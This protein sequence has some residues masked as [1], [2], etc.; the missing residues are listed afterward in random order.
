MKL[1]MI[2][3]SEDYDHKEAVW[4]ALSEL[5]KAF[6]DGPVR[7]LAELEDGS[8]AGAYATMWADN[9]RMSTPSLIT[10]QRSNRKQVK[11]RSFTVAQDLYQA[12]KDAVVYLVVFK[13]S[14]DF[15]DEARLLIEE[16]ENVPKIKIVYVDYPELK[17]LGRNR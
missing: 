5:D 10:F 14:D 12:G 15:S 2:T 13:R 4:Q 8:H 16:C 3:G 7:L 17:I 11:A 9:Q 6:E 1:L